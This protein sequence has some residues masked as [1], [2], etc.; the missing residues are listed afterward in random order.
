MVD[1]FTQCSF[2]VFNFFVVANDQD[3]VAGGWGGDNNNFLIQ[4][5]NIVGALNAGG[6][7]TEGAG[8]NGSR[9]HVG[10]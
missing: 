4:V 10:L 1:G 2:D 9:R 6:T 7:D 8:D 3:Q 5:T